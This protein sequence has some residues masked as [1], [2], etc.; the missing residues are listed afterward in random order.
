MLL[1]LQLPWPHL[2]VTHRVYFTGSLY[3]F[4]LRVLFTGSLYGFSFRVLYSDNLFGT[5]VLILYIYMGLVARQVDHQAI[6]SIL[7][8]A[9]ITTITVIFIKCEARI[10]VLAHQLQFVNC[11]YSHRHIMS[12]VCWKWLLFHRHFKN[13]DFTYYFIKS[14]SEI[15]HIG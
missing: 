12:K 3:G 9:Y 13:Y 4:S 8:C 5:I 1:E 14:T 11:T 15:V 6:Q 2:L 10:S 7:C